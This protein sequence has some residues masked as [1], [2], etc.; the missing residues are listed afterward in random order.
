MDR[1]EQTGLGVAIIGHVLLFGALSLNL[2]K[3]PVLPKFEN[4]PIEVAMVDEAALKSAAPAPT[5]TPAP[6]EASPPPELAPAPIIMAKPT[7]EP[8]APPPEP[9]VVA[10]PE[11]KPVTKPV[12]KAEPKPA[13][14][15]VAKARP[16]PEPIAVAKPVAKP[17]PIAKLTP[18]KTASADMRPRRIPGLSRSIV[19][20]LNDAPSETPT[21]SSTPSPAKAAAKPAKAPGIS[22]A[23][24]TGAQ[25]SS[26][27]ALIYRALKPYWKPPSGSDAELLVTRLSVKLNRD[28]SI[29]GE[30]EII[31]Q[32]GINDSN[33][34]QAKLHAERA[35]Q[36]VRRAA[37]FNLPPDYYDGWKW[38][39]PLKLYVG[40][41]G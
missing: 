19:S 40:Q 41:P 8:I 32:D 10:R 17:K 12:A 6:A 21:K 35:I 30:P 23:Q 5:P 31:G 13:T 15:P 36:A 11:P 38:L 25:K 27:N 28:G 14:K 37:P 2:L 16:K 33:R 1:A 26:L 18:T 24:M 22:L 3:P 39:K 34:G 4:P 29:D 20:G 7:P 9:K